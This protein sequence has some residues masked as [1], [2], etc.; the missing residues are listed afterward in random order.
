[1]RKGKK[2]HSQPLQQGLEGSSYGD[3]VPALA[4]IAELTPLH[5]FVEGLGVV[6]FFQLQ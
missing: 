5:D 6:L 1:M 4:K 2:S 3:L